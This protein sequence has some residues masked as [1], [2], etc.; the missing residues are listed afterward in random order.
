MFAKRIKYLRQ[1]RDLTQVQ[2]AAK[3]G[4][5]KQSISNWEN[6]N[7]MPSV[8]MLEKI[9]DFFSVSTDYL[10]GRENRENKD[11]STIDATGLS[12]RQIEHIMLIIEDLRNS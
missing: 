11:G 1:T 5:A 10:L 4:V 9:A 8:E 12:P 7:I 3:L 2:L 6:D